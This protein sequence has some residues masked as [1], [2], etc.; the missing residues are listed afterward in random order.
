[1]AL[2]SF[3]LPGK[4]ISDQKQMSMMRSYLSQLKD[5]TESELYDIKWDN[6]SQSLREKLDNLQMS[7]T[8]VDANNEYLSGYI[9]ANYIQA[10]QI[11]ADFI[12]SKIIT[13]QGAIVDTLQT[14]IVQA[15]FVDA[16]KV[17]AIVGEF[18]YVDAVAVRAIVG[19][20]DFIEANDILVNGKIK[21]SAL[22]ATTISSLFTNSNSATFGCINSKDYYFTSSTNKLYALTLLSVTAT[23]GKT[24][25]VLGTKTVPS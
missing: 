25:Y 9:A 2:P 21:S 12:C 19:E 13:A 5:E 15:G 6:L 18:G 7:V 11:T 17:T 16:E 3:N 24:A 14:A 20:Y 4:N 23:D 8:N 10:S 1:M 22:S